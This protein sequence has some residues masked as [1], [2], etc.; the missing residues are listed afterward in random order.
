M[1]G[2]VLVGDAELS[3]SEGAASVKSQG[4]TMRV[5]AGSK[6]FHE[7]SPNWESVYACMYTTVSSCLRF[8]Q[9]FGLKYEMES[10]KNERFINLK[11]H[12]IL[13]T[14]MKVHAVPS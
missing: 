10:S 13:G 11:L 9:S 14:R 2:K 1:G 7:S 4:I 5:A 3:S 12:V 6:A 8:Q